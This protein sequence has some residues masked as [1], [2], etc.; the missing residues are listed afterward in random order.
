MTLDQ[1][2][3]LVSIGTGHTYRVY[4]SGEV[5]VEYWAYMPRHG[6]ERRRK[7][8]IDTFGA[9]ARRCRAEARRLGFT[10]NP[11]VLTDRNAE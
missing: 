3:I 9:T 11:L 1:T 7:R 4:T 8:R 5:E 10:V 2:T 6:T